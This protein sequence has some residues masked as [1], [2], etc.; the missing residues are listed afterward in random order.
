MRPPSPIVRCA[1]CGAVRVAVAWVPNP[2]PWLAG[3]ETSGSAA[4]G[5][6]QRCVQ[7]HPQARRLHPSRGSSGYPGAPLR[8][9]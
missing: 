7:R 2:L 4:G 6:C 3:S 5:L 9:P 8:K 1:G